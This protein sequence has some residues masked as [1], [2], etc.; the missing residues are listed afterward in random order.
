MSIEDL[1]TFFGKLESD[2]ALQDKARALQ[3]GAADERVAGL[4]ALAAG[5]GLTVT[6]AD[7]GDEAA[8][9]AVAALDDASLRE[10]VGGVA[11]DAVG[12]LGISGRPL[13]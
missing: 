11:C 9:P 5:E 13:G 4:C 7:L 6:P 2:P 12:S 3:G 8:R 1:K 10:V